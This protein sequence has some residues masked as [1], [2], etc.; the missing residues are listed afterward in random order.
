MKL[1]SVE[2]TAGI[3]CLRIDAQMRG[4]D[5]L[6]GDWSDQNMTI[7]KTAVEFVFSGRYPTDEM[8]RC[9][10]SVQSRRW[11]VLLGIPKQDY[12]MKHSVAETV[13]R[14]IVANFKN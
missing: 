11:S 2:Q 1:V 6:V 7:E 13:S 8:A 3:N 10:S 12:F 5:C 4:I 9:L 14:K